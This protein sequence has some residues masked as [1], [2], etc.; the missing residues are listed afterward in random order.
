MSKKMIQYQELVNVVRGLSSDAMFD[1]FLNACKNADLPICQ[2]CLDAGADI[3][4]R[5]SYHKDTLLK[6]LVGS[7]KFTTEVG[8]WLIEKGADMHMVNNK[9]MSSLSM[10]CFKGEVEIVK[11]FI[12]KGIKI[13]PCENDFDEKS[14]LY[15]AVVGGEYEI[16]KMLL[17]L[18]ANIEYEEF[19][20]AVERRKWKI[21][22]LFLQN[23]ISADFNFG[24]CKP[25]H[26][27][28]KNQD[29]QTANILLKYNANVNEKLSP[30]KARH[31]LD[32]DFVVTPMDIA[33]AKKDID[34]QKLLKSFGGSV[35]SNEEKS[36]VFL[37]Y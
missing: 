34:M 13:R 36:E 28:T 18:G 11:S 6:A 17:K 27:A 1:F 7:G 2:I 35:S 37:K 26:I 8:D 30:R 4:I 16:V 33:V 12:D 23:G 14:D 29:I 19:Y 24:G 3:N 10:A 31:F 21:V 22:E 20:K 25:L 15:Y 9:G 32:K 5:E